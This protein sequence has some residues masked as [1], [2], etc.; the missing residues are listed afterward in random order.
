M[1]NKRLEG[2]V[3]SLEEQLDD[4]CFWL[5]V[6]AL[7]MGFAVF[8]F[9]SPSPQVSQSQSATTSETIALG[10]DAPKFVYPLPT[11]TPISSGYGMR[12][13]PVTGKETMHSGVDKGA[14]TGTPI[15]SVAD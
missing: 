2:R 14:A 1:T 13:H 5:F 10:K 9:G 3:N 12:T 4:V 11:K 15:Y 8:K 7:L 6:V